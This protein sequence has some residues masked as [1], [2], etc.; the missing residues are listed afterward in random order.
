VPV[1]L[2][3]SELLEI[4]EVASM[5]AVFDRL[6]YARDTVSQEDRSGRAS[7]ALIQTISYG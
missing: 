2:A 1:L 4:T 7:H 3:M 6:Q 5:C